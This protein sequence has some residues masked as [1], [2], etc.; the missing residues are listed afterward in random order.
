LAFDE[1][2]LFLSDDLVEPGGQRGGERGFY[3]HRGSDK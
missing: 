2:P 3:G 1:D